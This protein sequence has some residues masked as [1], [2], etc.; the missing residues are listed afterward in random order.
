MTAL[1]PFIEYHVTII[2]PGGETLFDGIVIARTP[3]DA[4]AH[5]WDSM[6]EPLTVTIEPGKVYEVREDEE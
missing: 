2:S 4:R 1:F 5:A 6:H 3:E